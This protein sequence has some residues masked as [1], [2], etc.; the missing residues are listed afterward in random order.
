M[1]LPGSPVLTDLILNKDPKEPPLILSP[2][3]RSS[4]GFIAY[5]IANFR[6]TTLS[7]VLHLV[8]PEPVSTQGHPAFGTTEQIFA[9]MYPSTGSLSRRNACGKNSRPLPTPAHNELSYLVKVNHLEWPQAEK[10][11]MLSFLDQL[12]VTQRLVKPIYFELYSSSHNNTSTFTSVDGPVPWMS[13]GLALSYSPNTT[14]DLSQKA[15]TKW[16]E[17]VVVKFERRGKKAKLF[18]I[19]CTHLWAYCSVGNERSQKDIERWEWARN[20]KELQNLTTKKTMNT[21][22]IAFPFPSPTLYM[23]KKPEHCHDQDKSKALSSCC[24]DWGNWSEAFVP[25]TPSQSVGF[26]SQIWSSTNLPQTSQYQSPCQVSMERFQTIC[27][28]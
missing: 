27:C 16:E 1:E 20:C 15:R 22:P 3:P 11:L 2:L 4:V 24:S 26:L 17:V 23:Q 18:C 14:G 9:L 21:L 5:A 28:C 19:V 6:Y 7:V 8:L 12:L 10:A 25:V 13:L